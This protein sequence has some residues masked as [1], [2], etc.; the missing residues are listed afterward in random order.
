MWRVY[1][2]HRAL[3]LILNVNRR[4]KE[5]QFQFINGTC[6]HRA[7][8]KADREE[9]RENTPAHCSPLQRHQSS[10]ERMDIRGNQGKNN[11]RDGRDSPKS[12]DGTS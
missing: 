8:R 10:D 7:E 9:V 3:G 4:E 11:Q 2:A 12:Q 5:I 6:D 1:P